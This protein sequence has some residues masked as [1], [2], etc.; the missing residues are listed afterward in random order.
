MSPKQILDELL[1]QHAH[2][3]ALL[4]DARDYAERCSRGEGD[5]TTLKGWLAGVLDAVRAHNRDEERLV[6]EVLPSLDE[7]AERG[8]TFM[9]NEH[10]RE[11]ESLFE[12]LLSASEDQDAARA[13][14]VALAVIEQLRT[15]MAAEERL[16]L[17]PDVLRD[18]E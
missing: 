16:F 9:S 6:G 11:H 8:A 15:H 14:R 13:G 3:R 10:V 18:R 12:A 5:W 7:W 1:G 4:A 17:R 2:L